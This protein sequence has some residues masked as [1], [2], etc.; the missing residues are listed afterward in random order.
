MKT[1]NVIIPTYNRLD[2]LRE[3]VN[4][5]VSGGYSDVY[6]YIIVDGNRKL[7]NKLSVEFV[8]KKRI[9][10]TFNNKR[11]DWVFSMNRGLQEMGDAEAVI[12]AADDIKFPFNS[13]SIVM[14]ELRNR[15]PD[16]D[17][18]IYLNQ[19]PKGGSSAFGLMGKKFIE[20]F[21]NKMVFCPDY[22]HYYSDTESGDFAR[23][24]KK[25]YFC[26]DVI[27]QHERAHDETWKLAR[28]ILDRDL[29]VRKNRK[30]RNILWGRDFERI[31]K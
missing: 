18:I 5:I 8:N 12:Y 15:F 24:I 29:K 21:P 26:K 23:S 16:T 28:P 10:M 22:I 25:Y 17:G 3:T 2:K 19:S 27:L 6:V 9:M 7:F 4:S 14:K 30:R 13:I 31:G 20:R 11:M 1:V